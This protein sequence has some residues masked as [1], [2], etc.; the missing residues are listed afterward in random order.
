[1]II[2]ICLLFA[3]LGAALKIGLWVWIM[4]RIFGRPPQQYMDAPVARRG[5]AG[6]VM[7]WLTILGTIL[8][9]VSTTVGLVEKCD[10]DDPEPVRYVM[11]PRPEPMRP[12]LGQR[13]CTPTVSCPMMM[14]GQIGSVCTCVGM[15]GMIEGRVCE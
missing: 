7:K 4:T 2:G 6:G 9:I 13:C 3:A 12:T 10:K 11:P 15:M 5:G 1:M 14:P 8:G